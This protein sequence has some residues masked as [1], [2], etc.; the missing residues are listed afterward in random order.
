MTHCGAYIDI[1][2]ELMHAWEPK[3][4]IK[5]WHSANQ[6][7]QTSKV[8][9]P[10]RFV[11]VQIMYISFLQPITDLLLIFVQNLYSE[12]PERVTNFCCLFCL[13]S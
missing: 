2:I 8:N 5:S 13:I 11:S 7:K 4:N 10:F 9:D 6:T 3:S 12:K 1:K